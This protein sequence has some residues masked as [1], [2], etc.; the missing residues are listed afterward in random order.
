M[1]PGIWP[2]TR[3]FTRKMYN[4]VDISHTWD[5]PHNLDAG[6]IAE[7]RFWLDNLNR[8]NGYSI[9]DKHAITKIVYSDASEH[10][11]GGYILQKLGNV[12]AHGTFDREEQGRSSAYRELAAVRRMLDSFSHLLRHQV[13]VWHSDNMNTA[14]IINV[15]S[16][17]DHLQALALDIFRMCLTYDTQLIS[18]WVPR[19]ENQLADS[20]SKYYGTDNWSIDDESFNFI[21]SQFGP[22]TI[23][24][25]A[26]ASNRNLPRFDY[27]FHCPGAENV[28]TFTSHWGND[29]NWLCPPIALVGDTLKH[30]RLCKAT[31]VL[32]V[33]EW[34]SSYYWPLLTPLT[35]R[36]FGSIFYKSM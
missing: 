10:S 23:D 3:F 9:K 6:T 18:K 4:F 20:I 29:F 14:N 27:R 15:G 11:Y 1:G 5:G 8:V 2:L 32:F 19:E 25:F 21:H 34:K 17:K 22:F 16:T 7:L 36:T 13:V 26:T 24:R 31:G 33:P 12:I 35:L 28:N 30:A